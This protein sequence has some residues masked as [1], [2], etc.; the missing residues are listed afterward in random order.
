LERKEEPAMKNLSSL[1]GVS[2]ILFGG[3]LVS[4]QI[5]PPFKQCPPVGADTSCEILIV[6]TNKAV[7]V[8]TD[9]SQGPYDGIEDTLLGVQNNSTGTVYSLPLSSPNPIFAFDGDGICGLS[10]NTGQPYVP[11]P[12]GCPY[13]PYGYEGPVLDAKGNT[14]G[15]VSFSSINGNQ[16]SGIVNFVDGIP[17]GGWAYFSLELAIQTV[18]SALSGQALSVPRLLQCPAPSGPK[19]YDGY[20]P[21]DTV[22]TI[23]KLGCALTSAAMII[24]YFGGT[25]DPGLLNSWLTQNKGYDPKHAVSWLA[26]A[27]YSTTVQGIA[28]TY[29]PGTNPNDFVVDNYLCSNDPVILQVLDPKGKTH[30]VVA[31]GGESTSGG[32]STYII[33]DPYFKCTTLAQAGCSY[34]NEYQGIRKLIHGP[35]PLSGLEIHAG[36][37]VELL[38]TAPNGQETGFSPSAGAVVEQIPASDYYTESIGDDSGGTADTPPVKKIEI[39]TP[40]AGQYTLQVIG[41][42]SGSFTLWFAGWDD[43]GTPSTQTVTGNTALG[44]STGYEVGYSSLP[45]SQIQVAGIPR[46]A[47]AISSTAPSGHGLEVTVHLA[48]TG[49]GSAQSIVLRQVTLRT[50]RGTGTVTLVRPTLPLSLGDLA[51][52]ESTNLFVTASVPST[53]SAFSITENGTMQSSLN[54]SYNY[55]VGQAVFPSQ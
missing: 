34:G 7:N 8:Y 38:V 51:A 9:S 21:G 30:F 16:T 11:A 35:A 53:V 18:C 47:G 48:N 22:H 27:S 13:G 4:A 42:G 37:P 3:T 6:V 43:N 44:Q 12:P 36:S 1:I 5:S 49:A 33:N 23:C 26:V 55:S 14:V 31:T 45:G 20:P 29:Q 32:Q 15:K 46:L 17:P 54:T 19:T 52:G 28:L 24:N 25:T 2:L 41:T 50:L 40:A 10:P 39:G